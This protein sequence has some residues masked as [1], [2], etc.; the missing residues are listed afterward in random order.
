MNS[1]KLFFDDTYLFEIDTKLVEI[2]KRE[3]Q[4]LCI[5]KKKK[6]L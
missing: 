5:V 1:K 3:D 6:K 2:T 4:F